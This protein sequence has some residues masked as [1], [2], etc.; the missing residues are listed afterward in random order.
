[1]YKK[2]ARREK[3]GEEGAQ[4]NYRSLSLSL[5]FALVVTM[6]IGRHFLAAGRSRLCPLS[7]T[8]AQAER[9][10]WLA[11]HG[12]STKSKPPVV[13]AWAVLADYFQV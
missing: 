11:C 5:S 13:D 8:E 2:R 6:A 7:T 4:V 12:V 1:M 3:G 9:R 10:T